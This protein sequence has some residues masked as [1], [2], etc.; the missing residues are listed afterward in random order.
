MLELEFA[1]FTDPGRVRE[2][3][4]DFVGYTLPATPSDAR[5]RGWL[6][7]LADGV[8]GQDRGEVASRLAVESLMEGFESAASGELHGAL[9]RRL[10]QAVNTRIFEARH[11]G[12][13]LS[14]MATTIVAC[15]LRFDR[16]TIAHVGDSRCYLIRRSRATPLTEDHTLVG[17]QVRLG[18]ISADKGAASATRH[19]LSR[20]LGSEMFVRAETR[21]VTLNPGDVLMLCSD[22]LHGA[23]QE[24]EIS[25]IAGEG[26]VL[27][28]AARNL[29]AIANER[30]GSDNITVQ[31]IRIQ[32]VERVGMY[33]GRP[34]RLRQ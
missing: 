19:L 21:E 29:V 34:Y 4:E 2:G 17:E 16:A 5:A 27:D 24:A 12:A 33:R 26:D 20:S 10:M 22:G 28:S 23:L 7:A 3:N 9:M 8:G 30:D 18:L 14:S 1:Q 32:S 6:F 15:A 13:Q 11:A 25:R 31:L